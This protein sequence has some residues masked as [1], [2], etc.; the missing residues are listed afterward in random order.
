MK[1]IINESGELSSCC[2]PY[3]ATFP[4]AM[5]A[6]KVYIPTGR[7]EPNKKYCQIHLVVKNDF[8]LIK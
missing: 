7:L 8:F 4:R 3:C 2:G 5:L 6:I 1:L